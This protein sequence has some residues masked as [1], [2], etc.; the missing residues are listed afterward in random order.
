MGI[1]VRSKDLIGLTGDSVSPHEH[2]DTGLDLSDTRG[3]LSGLKLKHP[4]K[5]FS[6]FFNAYARGVNLATGRTGAMFDRPF[7]RIPVDTT[8]YLMQLVLYIHQNP[9]KHRFAEDLREWNYSTYHLLVSEAPTPLQKE[10]VIQLFGSKQDFVRIHQ[11]IQPPSGL[12]D[13]E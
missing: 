13:E 2:V 7:K 1:L 8:N 9:Q 4:S 10:R 12:D 5:Y 11:E 3:D 6:G